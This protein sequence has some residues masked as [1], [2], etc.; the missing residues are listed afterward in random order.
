MELVC[1]IAEACRT[2]PVGLVEGQFVV[3]VRAR[4]VSMQ[5]TGKEEEAREAN[6]KSRSPENNQKKEVR[7]INN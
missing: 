7:T 6:K 5:A 1:W 2:C 3:D 4:W